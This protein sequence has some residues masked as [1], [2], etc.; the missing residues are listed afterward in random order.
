MTPDSTRPFIRAAILQLGTGA[1]RLNFSET[2]DVT[3]GALF[4]PS[5]FNLRNTFN[6]QTA[7]TDGVNNADEVACTG[8][9][10]NTFTHAVCHDGSAAADPY[11]VGDGGTACLV[12]HGGTSFTPK[13]CKNSSGQDTGDDSSLAACEGVATG[14]LFSQAVSAV[15]LATLDSSQISVDD[16][17]LDLTFSEAQRV[18][19]IKISGTPGGDGVPALLT[20]QSGAYFDV[21][22]NSNLAQDFVLW[23]LRTQSNQFCCLQRSIW[24]LEGL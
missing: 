17:T 18:A 20:S 7:C 6:D 19:A 9:T 24:G 11:E 5:N 15:N 10:G 8:L 1:V 3:P 22:G 14:E 13:S 23:K 2:I 4:N 21:A 16:T 12:T